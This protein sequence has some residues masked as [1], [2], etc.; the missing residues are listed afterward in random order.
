MTVGTQFLRGAAQHRHLYQVLGNRRVRLVQHAWRV[1][2]AGHRVHVQRW[3]VWRQPWRRYVIVGSTG[4][5]LWSFGCPLGAC[6]RIV[7]ACNSGDYDGAA[8][9]LETAAVEDGK[10]DLATASPCGAT[11]CPTRTPCQ[12]EPCRTPPGASVQP[13]D[14]QQDVREEQVQP[15]DQAQSSQ[16]APAQSTNAPQTPQARPEPEETVEVLVDQ[17]TRG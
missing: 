10:I 11:P 14:A 5:V 2:P 1:P 7:Q 12:K 15:A 3:D 16:P 9:L 4:V 6:D 13:K 8:A 17:P